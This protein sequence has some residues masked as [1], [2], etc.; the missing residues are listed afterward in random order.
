MNESRQKTMH[1]FAHRGHVLL[2]L[3]LQLLQLLDVTTLMH[4]RAQKVRRERGHFV[5]AP[6]RTNTPTMNSSRS[7][8]MPIK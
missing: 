5:Q 2:E 7:M 6:E 3:A 8:S 1:K 4:V